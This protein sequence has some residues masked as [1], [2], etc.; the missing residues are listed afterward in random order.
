MSM[1]RLTLTQQMERSGFQARTVSVDHLE[2]LRKDIETLRESMD[3]LFY[4]EYIPAFHFELPRSMPDAQSLIVLARPQP[5]L[6]VTLRHDGQMWPLT[7]PPTYADA[8]K[9]DE[10]AVEALN[11]ALSPQTY[12]FIKAR[13]PLKALAARSGLAK[14]GRNNITYIPRFGSF[15]RLTAFY[16]DLP[17]TE[18]QWQDPEV[19]PGCEG[20]YACMRG[21]PT[22]AIPEDRFL[23]RAERCLTYMNEKDTSVPFPSW[24]DPQA[25]NALV[26]CMRCQRLCPYNKAALDFVAARGELSEEETALLLS[27]K[28]E[29]ESAFALDEKLRGMGLDPALFPRNLEVLLR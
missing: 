23:V 7:I 25:H 4:E 26:G 27:G 29:G 21:C 13:L 16:S 5:S 11:A 19:L 14:Y 24:V 6:M 3:P 20:C 15:H 22:G 2:D 12:R 17:C 8:S 1:M 28:R 18:D 9:A 10:D